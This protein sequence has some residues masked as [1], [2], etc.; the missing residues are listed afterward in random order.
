MAEEVAEALAALRELVD[1]NRRVLDRLEAV[2]ARIGH[3]EQEVIDIR[4]ETAE[5][6]INK[7]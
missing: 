4:L 2:D 5:V 3:V 1:L 7:R 6:A